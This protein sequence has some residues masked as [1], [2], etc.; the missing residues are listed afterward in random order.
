VKRERSVRVALTVARHCWCSV[1]GAGEGTIAISR[2][3]YNGLRG[4]GLLSDLD[5]KQERLR[6]RFVVE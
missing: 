5:K 6:E 1:R 4:L 2:G 3:D